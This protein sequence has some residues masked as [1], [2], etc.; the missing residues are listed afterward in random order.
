MNHGL[1]H[2][3]HGCHKPPM[4]PTFSMID[5]GR[6]CTKWE[7]SQQDPAPP[8]FLWHLHQLQLGCPMPKVGGTQEAQRGGHVTY[9]QHT[10][11]LG[12]S[13]AG[14]F[15]QSSHFGLLFCPKSLTLLQGRW[16]Q[17]CR[18]CLNQQHVSDELLEKS[19]KYGKG[20]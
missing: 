3:I 5:P 13:Q 15:L 1:F 9:L 19:L 7:E 4:L 8:S 12:A 20:F 6:P 16:R 17:F 2:P 18:I 14:L 11:K 10:L